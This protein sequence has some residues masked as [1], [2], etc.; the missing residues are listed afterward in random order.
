MKNVLVVFNYNAGRRKA[1]IYKKTIHKFLLERCNKFKFIA[2]EEL[3]DTNLDE[4][5]TIF[6]V[7]GD[8][9]VNKVATKA[10]KAGKNLALIPSGTANLLANKL[11][12]PNDLKNALKVVDKNCVKKIDYI[13][14]NGK[15]CYLRC[16]FGYDCDIVCKTPQTLKNRFGYL[17]YLFAGIIFAFRLQPRMYEINYDGKTMNVEATCLIV[18]NAANMYQNMSSIAQKSQPDDGLADIFVLKAK[19]PF[20]FISEFFRILFGVTKD[21]GY[22]LYFTA[23]NLSIKNNW[24]VCHI[25][26]EKTKLK[27]DINISVRPKVLSVYYNDSNK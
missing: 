15:E 8:G 23:Q 10:A 18:A 3:E 13:D 12:I 17:S 20:T 9:T 6:A 2:V 16:G 1:T 19:N 11:G 22:A 4:Y 14:I 5:D 7:G 21:S 27:D 24:A 25:D 26:G